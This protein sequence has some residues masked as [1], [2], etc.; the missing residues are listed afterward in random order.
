MARAATGRRSGLTGRS[1]GAQQREGAEAQEL[2]DAIGPGTY[3]AFNDAFSLGLHRRW[4]RLAAQEALPRGHLARR[5]ALDACCGTGDLAQA[6][7]E[8]GGS[9]CSVTGV[10]VSEELLSAA[11]ARSPHVAF[12]RED[13][14][15]LSFPANSF[16]CA[17]V[18]YGLRN[19][20]SRASMMRELARVLRPNCRLAVLDFNNAGNPASLEMQVQRAALENAV[21]PAARVVGLGAEYEYLYPS[22]EG[23]ETGREQELLALQNGFSQA[24]HQPIAGGLMGLLVAIK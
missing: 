15:D 13:A 14:T 18:G 7:R 4:K 17:T 23:F 10:D 1:A 8:L 21:V 16:D 6:L 11:R 19:V 22:I 12:L 24:W 5:C 20:R 9:G 2:F 3:D